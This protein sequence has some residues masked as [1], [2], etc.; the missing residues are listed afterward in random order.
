[1]AVFFSLPLLSACAGAATPPVSYNATTETY[2]VEGQSW[3]NLFEYSSSPGGNYL[4]YVASQLGEEP[5]AWLYNREANTHHQL[6]SNGYFIESQARTDDNGN[7]ALVL[8]TTNNSHSQLVYNGE[9]I[10]DN[11]LL[12]RSLCFWKDKLFYAAWDVA[13]G[14]TSL[15][16]YDPEN[17]SEK[18]LVER[19]SL[20]SGLSTAAGDVILLE[21]YDAATKSNTVLSVH[22][23]V[24]GEARVNTLSSGNSFLLPYGESPQILQISGDV[25]AKYLFNAY[26]WL[27]RYQSGEPWSGS[28]DSAGRVSWNESYRLLGLIELWEKTGD[29]SLWATISSSV[30][31]LISTR[32]AA[33]QNGG[34]EQDGFLFVT[35]K[36]SLDH[37]TELR[38]LVNNA[39]VYWPMLRA[40]NTDCLE[41]EIRQPLLSM[42]EAAFQYYEKDWD[43]VS[44]CYRYRKGEPTSFDGSVMPFNQQ[45]AFGLC[46][47]ELWKATGKNI[48]WNRCTALAQTFE[49]E[50]KV[51]E[52]GRIIWHYWPQLFY[53]GWTKGDGISKNTPSRDPMVNPPYED[54]SHASITALF[55]LEYFRAFGDVFSLTQVQGLRR[56]LDSICTDGGFSAIVEPVDTAGHFLS[57]LWSFHTV[58]GEQQTAFARSLLATD[59]FSAMEFDSQNILSHAQLYNPKAGGNLHATVFL[60]ENNTLCPLEKRVFPLS[61]I[62]S[63]TERFRTVPRI[64]ENSISH[65]FP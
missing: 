17:G 14:T 31:K 28:P 61:R 34:E 5:E 18:I 56:T 52:D 25:N 2:T 39:M 51:T 16:L 32:K 60:Y 27:D 46:L 3:T 6:T 48:Y 41:E 9:V 37:Q 20:S 1:M 54:T 7:W 45:N 21:A 62:P 35:K 49:K 30:K 38:L 55:I 29:E 64:E 42:A 10:T 24:E 50:L 36:Y 59:T 19:L 8:T 4:I 53:D 13:A 15:F 22:P 23:Q 63:L 58:L 65:I 33:F 40:V 43:S 44:G 57:P 11:S 26:Y 47:I 12:N